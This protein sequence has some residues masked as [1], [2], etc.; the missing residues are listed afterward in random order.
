MW[1]FAPLYFLFLTITSEFFWMWFMLVLFASSLWSNFFVSV[2]ISACA[3]LFLYRLSCSLADARRSYL[4]RMQRICCHAKKKCNPAE[5]RANPSCGHTRHCSTG[6][7]C[8]DTGTGRAPGS[9]WSQTTRHHRSLTETCHLWRHHITTKN[10]AKKKMNAIYDII[11]IYEW[12]R[13]AKVKL[14]Y[15]PLPFSGVVK[16]LPQHQEVNYI[17]H[18]VVP[19]S[20]QEICS[21]GSLLYA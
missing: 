21:S 8:Q 9:Q 2:C 6:T 3:F 16:L 7:S 5:N 17:R 4:M 18:V 12:S 14:T 15:A 13:T 10:C 19:A 20:S 11:Y 1:H